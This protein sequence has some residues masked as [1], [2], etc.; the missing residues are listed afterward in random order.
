[1]YG[2]LSLMKSKENEL[3]PRHSRPGL[4]LAWRYTTHGMPI[5]L[6][7]ACENTPTEK[8]DTSSHKRLPLYKKS[9]PL[10]YT[11]KPSSQLKVGAQSVPQVEV[12][13]FI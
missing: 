3:Q 12:L 10:D 5:T 4:G 8:V 7:Q 1:M 11:L 6:L 9:P 13:L 2:M